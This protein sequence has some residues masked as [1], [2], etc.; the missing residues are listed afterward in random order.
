M[1]KL[2][3]VAT[4]VSVI[5]PTKANQSVTFFLGL[6]LMGS[7]VLGQAS[8][9]DSK[10]FQR[11]Q[12]EV[13]EGKID[14]AYASVKEARIKKK[15]ADKKY[16]ELFKTLGEQ[17]ADREAAKGEAACSSDDLVKCEAQLKTAK[18]F[19]TTPGVTRLQGVF[20]QKLGCLLY[21]SP[22]PRDS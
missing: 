17:L 2:S 20:D 13:K 22:S 3:K 1:S 9:S 16:D 7:L 4:W 14:E 10:L 12:V 11:A 15:K 19:A 18:E 8:L 21:T 5:R 6:I